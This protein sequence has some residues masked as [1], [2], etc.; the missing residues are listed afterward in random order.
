MAIW[1]QGCIRQGHSGYVCSP[2]P[3][4][5]SQ[6]LHQNW[7]K[8]ITPFYSVSMSTNTTLPPTPTHTQTKGGRD[9][10]RLRCCNL[11]FKG[12]VH[13]HTDTDRQT[14]RQSL[15]RK[16]QATLKPTPYH[17]SLLP[18]L[19]HSLQSSLLF[20]LITSSAVRGGVEKW[21]L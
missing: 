7:Q 4:I 19:L 21:L 14:D 16:H 20:F 3:Y 8:K 2:F 6:T 18:S 15:A 13:R 5:H 9:S 11:T 17:I 1:L 10:P 12:N